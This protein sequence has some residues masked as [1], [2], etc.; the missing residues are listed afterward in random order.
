MAVR[1]VQ[2]VAVKP[3]TSLQISRCSTVSRAQG[4]TH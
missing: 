2:L 3:G 1:E 4:S